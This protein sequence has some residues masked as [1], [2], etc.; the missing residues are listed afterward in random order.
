[1]VPFLLFLFYISAFL[2]SNSSILAIN[3]AFIVTSSISLD[4][5]ESSEAPVERTVWLSHTLLLAFEF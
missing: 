4:D 3:A 2:R 5:D 1:M